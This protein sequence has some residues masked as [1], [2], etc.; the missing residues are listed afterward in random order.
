LELAARF[1]AKHCAPPLPPPL[2][3]LRIPREQ[4]SYE[5]PHDVGLRSTL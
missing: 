3:M 1:F 2:A 5:G 4:T